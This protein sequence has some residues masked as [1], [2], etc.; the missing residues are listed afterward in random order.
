MNRRDFCRASLAL[1]PIPF[2]GASK[3]L[4]KTNPREVIVE[5]FGLIADGRTD[6]TA[7]YQAM[8]RKVLPGSTLRFSKGTY[9]FRDSV[10]IRDLNLVGCDIDHS[11]LV[12]KDFRGRM[13]NCHFHGQ[14]PS[15]NYCLI[16][17]KSKWWED[18]GF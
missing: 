7:A 8:V 17:E 10:D 16:V 14:S 13:E 9:L 3:A 2:L 12:M 15:R 6:N 4:A 18:R 1:L 11:T 5:D